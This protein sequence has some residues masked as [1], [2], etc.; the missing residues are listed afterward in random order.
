MKFRVCLFNADPAS[1]KE[2]RRHFADLGNIRI[3]I[4]TDS[5]AE[6]VAA[7]LER[8]IDLVVVHFDP[9]AAKAVE[10]VSAVSAESKASIIGISGDQNPQT[11]VGAVRAGCRQFVLKPI[12][13]KELQGAVDCLLTDCP[14]PKG[15]RRIAV[16]GASG[17]VGATTIACNLAA[18]FA[19]IRNGAALLDAHFD[20]GDVCVSLDIQNPKATIID[21][22]DGGGAIDEEIVRKAM[23]ILNDNLA[24]LGCPK[25]TSDA[26]RVSPDQFSRL[27][28][29][30]GDIYDEV[31]IDTPR[32]LLPVPIAV[33]EQADDVLVVMQLS[34][35]SIRNAMRY[36]DELLANGMP[37]EQIRFVLNRYRK[38]HGRLNPDEVTT[39]LDAPLFAVI[40]NNFKVVSEALD[41]GRVLIAE[42]KG[43]PVRKA[44]AAMARKFTDDGKAAPKRKLLN[45]LSLGM[46]S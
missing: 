22:F 34:V 10:V 2:L 3:V 42:N 7:V 11:L 13:P 25:K 15:G 41:F 1:S 23:T 32:A 4:E 6:T 19:R 9:D 38:N 24:I 33:L 26:W 37:A 14:P 36:R 27:I 20:F 12:D 40:P 44:I 18:E 16:V 21:L 17:G 45:T 39:Q 43:C 28:H 46:L 8:G 30:L 31:V 35:S 5:T 29:I